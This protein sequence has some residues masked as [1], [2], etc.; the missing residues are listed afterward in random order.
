MGMPG[1]GKGTVS[2]RL[3]DEL[4]ILHVSTGDMLR[5]EIASGSELGKELKVLLDKGHFASNELMYDLVE[6]FLADKDDYILDGFPRNLKQAEF[7]YNKGLQINTYSLDLV[8]S[9]NISDELAVERMLGRRYCC[10]CNQGYH[11]KNMPPMVEG[12][13]DKCGGTLLQRQDDNLETI[14]ER[15]QRYHQ[16]TSPLVEFYEKKNL[17]YQIDASK[18]FNDFYFKIKS[19]IELNDKN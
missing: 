7:W 16:S 14:E 17:L 3:V 6:S 15:I 9:L 13:C 12:I 19:K 5:A 18:P 11:I 1:A 10:K 2:S 4:G 8:I